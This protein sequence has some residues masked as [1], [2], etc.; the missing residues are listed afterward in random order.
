MSRR[1]LLVGGAGFIGTH[2]ARRLARE[3]HTVSVVDSLL[4]QV[5]GTHVKFSPELRTVARCVKGDVRRTAVLR[6]LL[7]DHDVI[8]W[9]AAETGTGQSP[10]SAPPMAPWCPGPG[11]RKNSKARSLP[12]TFPPC[13]PAAGQP[14]AVPASVAPAM[15]I[16]SAA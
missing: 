16:T 2:L 10:T 14:L 1:M 8:Y 3:G 13:P 7:H 6:P 12:P 11:E 9:L 4:S 15:L 5:H